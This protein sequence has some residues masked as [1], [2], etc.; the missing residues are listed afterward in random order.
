MGVV[1]QRERSQLQISASLAGTS[2]QSPRWLCFASLEPIIHLFAAHIPHDNPVHHFSGAS[3]LHLI[4]S[5]NRSGPR[6][7]S[8]VMLV[9]SDE[10]QAYE[11]RAGT[12]SA[13]RQLDVQHPSSRAL[14]SRSSTCTWP[15]NASREKQTWIL[16]IRSIKLG[17][18]LNVEQGHGL[19]EAETSVEIISTSEKDV[20]QVENIF[21]WKIRR[22]AA[23][24][25]L[26]LKFS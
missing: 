1:R 26:H 25:H 6:D 14:D 3:V 7:S 16:Y 17:V 20:E 11:L 22:I 13:S 15:L 19:Y 9:I 10:C 21:N 24:S 2:H 18:A 4:H 12:P 8:F 23:S 5:E